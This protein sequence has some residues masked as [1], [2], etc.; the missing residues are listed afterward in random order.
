MKRIII[1]LILPLILVNVYAQEPNPLDFSFDAEKHVLGPREVIENHVASCRV[2]EPDGDEK[3]IVFDGNGRVINEGANTFFHI[4][5]PY[6]RILATHIY[7]GNTYVGQYEY[8]YDEYDKL[9]SIKKRIEEYFSSE[10]GTVELVY[11]DGYLVEARDAIVAVVLGTSYGH[12]YTYKYG[13]EGGDLSTL[14][15]EGTQFYQESDQDEVKASA[16]QL[17]EY[18]DGINMGGFDRIFWYETTLDD[19][20][21]VWKRMNKGDMTDLKENPGD[22]ELVVE[23]SYYPNGLLKSKTTPTENLRYEYEY[24][25]PAKFQ[26]I[27]P[28]SLTEFR[29]WN[30]SQNYNVITYDVSGGQAS[31][32]LFVTGRELYMVQLTDQYMLPFIVEPGQEIGLSVSESMSNFSESDAT[33]NFLIQIEQAKAAA[34][35]QQPDNA[36]RIVAD[37]LIESVKQYPDYMG[38]LFYT[39]LWDIQNEKDLFLTYAARMIEL[40]PMNFKAMEM[41]TILSR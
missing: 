1:A 32:D 35:S 26:L 40:Y 5:S 20:G 2:I 19:E 6:K 10:T 22:Y 29:I 16:Y 23:Y 12:E 33:N 34:I 37:M 41:Y 21:R 4:Y 14:E 30:Y 3:L 25:D 9:T 7:T 28:E 13:Y 24:L 11:E 31:V 36:A 18:K 27:V 15:R 17:L 38:F 39:D 8:T